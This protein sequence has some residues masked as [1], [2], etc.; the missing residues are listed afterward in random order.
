MRTMLESAIVRARRRRERWHDLRAA[1]WVAGVAGVVFWVV[2]P[3][4]P[5]AEAP[6]YKRLDMRTSGTSTP[7]RASVRVSTGT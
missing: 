7:P 2:P 1:L 3:L 6:S 4:G 5:A